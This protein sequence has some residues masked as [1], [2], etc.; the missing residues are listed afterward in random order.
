MLAYCGINCQGCSAYKATVNTDL[1]LLKSTGES[2]LHGRYKP[3][4][5]VCLG[6]TPADQKFIAKYCKEC[7]VRKCAIEKGVQI[8]AECHEFENCD[9]VRE[10]IMEV[11]ND[12]EE[13]IK[14]NPIYIRMNLLR[15]RFLDSK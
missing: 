1:E 14:D 7:I 8:C 12:D 2:Y 9:I 4:D 5:W 13:S 15:K 6:C 10:S 3:E 11:L